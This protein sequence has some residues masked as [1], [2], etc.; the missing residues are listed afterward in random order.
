MKPQNTNAWAAPAPGLSRIVC[1]WSSTSST[2]RLSRK[3]GWSNLKAPAPAAIRRTRVATWTRKAPRKTTASSQ[4]A[5]VDVD[6]ATSRFQ[7]VDEGGREV[8]QIA[9]D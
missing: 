3:A 1:R 2:K 9:D 7:G 5:I 4:S 6:V 8:E